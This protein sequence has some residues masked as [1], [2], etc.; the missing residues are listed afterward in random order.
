MARWSDLPPLRTLAIA[1]LLL[2]TPAVTFVLIAAAA[3]ADAGLA[4]WLLLVVLPLAL[5]GS[6][7]YLLTGERPGWLRSPAEKA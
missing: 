1:L 7:I 3:T 2:A 6:G 5:L 4:G